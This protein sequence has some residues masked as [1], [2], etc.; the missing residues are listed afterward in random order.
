LRQ[1]IKLSVTSNFFDLNF[2]ILCGSIIYFSGTLF[3]YLFSKSLYS[4]TDFNQLYYLINP[5][6][7]IFRNSLFF[8][9]VIISIKE[10][11]YSKYSIT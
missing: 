6:I 10:I 1:K 3:L 9:A 4:Q 7:L 5:I 8:I 11:N 2:Y